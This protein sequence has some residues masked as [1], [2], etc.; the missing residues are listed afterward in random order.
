M[1]NVILLM[2]DISD[3]DGAGKINNKEVR[4]NNYEGITC[5]VPF[6][7]NNNNKRNKGLLSSEKT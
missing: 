4:S 1:I 6:C 3:Y 7:Y 2:E 5:C